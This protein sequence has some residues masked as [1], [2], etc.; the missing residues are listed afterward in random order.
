[1]QNWLDKISLKYLLFLVVQKII[2]IIS[3]EG[4][5]SYGEYNYYPYLRSAPKVF[6]S[7]FH[8]GVKLLTLFG[9]LPS[10]DFES[11]V[12]CGLGSFVLSLFLLHVDRC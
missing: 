4:N 8:F 1:M 6:M 2:I 11:F 7:F 9:G 12:A 3:I 5:N 10:G